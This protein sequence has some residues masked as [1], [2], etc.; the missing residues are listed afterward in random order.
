M[1]YYEPLH[2]YEDEAKIDLIMAAI[3]NGEEITPI[4]IVEDSEISLTGVH[5]LEAFNRVSKI[6]GYEDI[7]IPVVEITEE[8]FRSAIEA[9]N[10]EYFS[11]VHDMNNFCKSLYNIT[12]NDEVKKA[13]AD[14]F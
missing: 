11:E 6:D 5:R 2:D 1:D 13:L 9:E 3:M 8:E 4:V 7:E 12:E 14:Q 10:Y